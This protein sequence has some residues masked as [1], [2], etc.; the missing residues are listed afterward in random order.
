[1][2][3]TLYSVGFGLNIAIY[4][5]LNNRFMNSVNI[6]FFDLLKEKKIE[7]YN[8]LVNFKKILFRAFVVFCFIGLIAL[9]RVILFV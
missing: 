1:M 8:F 5:Y 9:S 2:I 7:P 4:L 3:F 6:P